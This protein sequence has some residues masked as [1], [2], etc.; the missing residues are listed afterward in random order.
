M[1]L[2]IIF[3]SALLCF[4][5]SFLVS[6]CQSLEICAV[7]FVRLIASVVEVATNSG[8]AVHATLGT[9]EGCI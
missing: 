5:F 4:M 2:F 8:E 3:G 7:G 9:G 6:I 1:Y